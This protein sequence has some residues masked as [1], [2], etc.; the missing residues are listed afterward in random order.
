M[1]IQWLMEI[2]IEPRRPT[3]VEL[4]EH[5]WLLREEARTS[6]DRLNSTVLT[7]FQPCDRVAAM[8]LSS[9]RSGRRHIARPRPA[10]TRDDAL[11]PATGF[12]FFQSFESLAA[13]QSA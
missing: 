2:R 13:C 10:T 4:S 8:R 3:V 7:F 11:P 1:S 9:D 12:T 6:A 5:D